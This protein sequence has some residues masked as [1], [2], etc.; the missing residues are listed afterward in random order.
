MVRCR[1]GYP[2][3][4]KK[5]R[6]CSAGSVRHRAKRRIDGLLAPFSVRT[7]HW[8]PSAPN[9]PQGSDGRRG[10][11]ARRASRGRHGCTCRRTKARVEP[12]PVRNPAGR[13]DP[14]RACVNATETGMDAPTPRSSHVVY[15]ILE[16][17]LRTVWLEKIQTLPRS[18]QIG[19]QGRDDHRMLGSGARRAVY[20]ENTHVSTCGFAARSAQTQQSERLDRP[21]GSSVA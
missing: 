13:E 12:T 21:E 2:R 16:A 6:P 8:R 10:R 9:A 17:S 18:V 11:S 7:R 4:S 14:M 1:Y 15:A 19:E 3:R 5:A 20:G